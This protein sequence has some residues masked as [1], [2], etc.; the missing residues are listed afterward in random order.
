M[1]RSLWD[2]LHSPIKLK[3]FLDL[4]LG[5]FC[6]ISFFPS[7]MGNFRLFQQA[8]CEVIIKYTNCY[9]LEHEWIRT[10]IRTLETQIDE[11]NK[12]I[13]ARQIVTGSYRRKRVHL[14]GGFSWGHWL[15]PSCSFFEEKYQTD[16]N[17]RR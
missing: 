15:A 6:K 12:T 4:Y 2:S 13:E 14:I 16:D 11:N 17:N 3:V 5:K 10:G 8:R 7:E 1:V 9:L